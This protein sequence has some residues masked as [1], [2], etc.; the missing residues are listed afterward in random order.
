MKKYDG[1]FYK[2]T[3]DKGEIEV[4]NQFVGLSIKPEELKI[5]FAKSKYLGMDPSDLLRKYILETEVFSIPSVVEIP[6]NSN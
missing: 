5:L 2:L 1:L 3:K 4:L 6:L